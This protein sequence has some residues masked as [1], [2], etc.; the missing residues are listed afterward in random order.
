MR[1]AVYVA[2]AAEEGAKRARGQ[3]FGNQGVKWEEAMIGEYL[4]TAVL[5]PWPL[6]L[7][8]P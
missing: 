8:V 4:E 6:G 2:A 1:P 3:V 7:L 5:F